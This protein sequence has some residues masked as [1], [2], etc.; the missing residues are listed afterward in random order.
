MLIRVVSHH[1]DNPLHIDK[2]ICIKGLPEALMFTKANGKRILKEPW[3][4][5]PIENIPKHI[6]SAFEPE[7]VSVHTPAFQSPN[8]DKYPALDDDIEVF[9]VQIDYQNGQG[10]STWKQIERMIDIHTPRDEKVKAPVVVCGTRFEGFTITADDIPTIDFGDKIAE[11][12][13]PKKTQVS[14]EGL[15]CPVCSKPFEREQQLRMHKARTGHRESVA[16][17]AH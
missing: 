3:K 4:L 12:E 14:R 15:R 16:V 5:D 9:A 11:E 17:T 10:E 8:G 7:T 13:K 6:R 2:L 1:V